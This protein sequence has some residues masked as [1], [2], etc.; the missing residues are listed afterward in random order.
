MLARLGD[1]AG[2]L[3]GTGLFHEFSGFDGKSFGSPQTIRSFGSGF[4]AIPRRWPWRFFSSFLSA[5]CETA[6]CLPVFNDAIP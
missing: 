1:L 3:A 6:P 5:S 2:C 4:G